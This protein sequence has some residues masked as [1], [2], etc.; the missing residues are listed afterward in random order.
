MI[1][2]RE[3]SRC[4]AV[5]AGAIQAHL[6]TDPD[7]GLRL[8]CFG[9]SDPFAIFSGVTEGTNATL[10]HGDAKH[11][12][13]ARYLVKYLVLDVAENQLSPVV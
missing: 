3:S 6:R 12:G 8:K 10:A 7:A 4:P 13:I 9:T 2:V 11:R 5:P 1:K